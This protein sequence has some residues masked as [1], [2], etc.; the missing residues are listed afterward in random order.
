M[1]IS[2]YCPNWIGDAVMAIPFVTELKRKHESSRLFVLCRPWVAAIYEGNP[3][4]E[5][6]IPVSGKNVN[7]IWGAFKDGRQLRKLEIELSFTLSNSFRSAMILRLSG[8]NERIGYTAQ[9]RSFL[10]TDPVVLRKGIFH[11]AQKYLDLF[12]GKLGDHDHYKIYMSDE[13][14]AW[15]HRELE[16]RNINNPI[17]LFPFSMAKSRTIPTEKIFELI[18]DENRTYVILG[19]VREQEMA[20]S[21][22]NN[23]RG[24]NIVSLCGEYTIRQSMALMSIFQYVI[25][26][27]SGLGHVSSML[28]IPTISIFGAGRIGTTRP[29]GSANFTVSKKVEC[30]PCVKNLCQNKNNPMICLRSISRDDILDVLKKNQEFS[31]C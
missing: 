2:V 28:G 6:V 29:L 25:A 10:L 4:I 7:G 21:L 26:T 12:G 1:N 11:R 15:A 18:P 27:D 19:S 13:E 31:A 5:A 24:L 20:E 16:D 9:G 30:S 17:G 22:V 14:R 23:D 8:A 3:D